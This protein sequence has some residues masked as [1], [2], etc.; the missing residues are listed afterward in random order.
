MTKKKIDEEINEFLQMWGCDE[1]VGF[2]KSIIPLF[3]LYDLDENDDWK[4]KIDGDEENQ[5]NVRLISTVYHM[6][7]ISDLF[8]KKLSKI[9]KRHE[10]LWQRME[11]VQ[12]DKNI[13]I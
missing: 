13:N 10:N 7:K 5:R 1:I 11:K 8:S 2:T 4:E 6:S 9:K 12:P 3:D